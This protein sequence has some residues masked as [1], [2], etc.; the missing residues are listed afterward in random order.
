[1]IRIFKGND[2]KFV[3]QGVYN[4]LYKPLGYKPIIEETKQPKVVK[5]IEEIKQPKTIQHNKKKIETKES[6][7]EL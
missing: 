2:I 6:S 4:S 5:P 1:M 3:T 7:E